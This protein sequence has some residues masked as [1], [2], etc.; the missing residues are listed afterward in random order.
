MDNL[1]LGPSRQLLMTG[2]ANLQ[3]LGAFTFTFF[4]GFPLLC[5][6]STGGSKMGP[7]APP[8]IWVLVSERNCKHH[9]RCFNLRE[10]SLPSFF[11]MKH[12]K[13]LKTF[14]K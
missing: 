11:K 2:S 13:V 8:S 7:A 1:R 6:S 4:S 14:F 12:S 3:S 9:K 10:T 5:I